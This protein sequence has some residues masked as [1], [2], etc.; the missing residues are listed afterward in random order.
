[1]TPSEI[2][3]WF[4]N[5]LMLPAMGMLAKFALG[6]TAKKLERT[7]QNIERLVERVEQLVERFSE[8]HTFAQ[9]NRTRIE[10][11]ERDVAALREKQH[12]LANGLNTLALQVKAGEVRR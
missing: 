9:V 4:V 1:M 2:P 10:A 11:L 3:P 12:E 5:L 7:E 8:Q 6:D